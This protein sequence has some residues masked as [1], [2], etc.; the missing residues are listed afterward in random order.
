MKS[1]IS[2]SIGDKNP[3][4]ASKKINS[5]NHKG[6]LDYIN[7]AQ[8][9]LPSKQI[10]RARPIADGSIIEFARIS[11]R[12]TI[13]VT[14][15]GVWVRSFNRDRSLPTQS[16]PNNKGS[17]E[18]TK[19]ILDTAIVLGKRAASVEQKL[20]ALSVINWIWSLVSQYHVTHP[21]PQLMRE[22][23]QQFRK[24]GRDRLAEWAAEKALEETGHDRL[25]LRDIQSLGYQAQALVDTYMP[26]SA[27]ILI[28]YFVGSVK[29]S[30]PIKV[31]GYAYTLE[32]IALAVKEKHIQA[33]EAIM[34]PKVNA[35]RCIRVHSS[36]G[37]DVEH[38]DEALEMICKLS[39]AERT[40]IAIAC[41]ETARLYFSTSEQDFPLATKLREQLQPFKL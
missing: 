4:E 17:I 25:A 31:V 9:S 28:D 23:A 5:G 10:L 24:Q 3:F 6:N 27:R 38:V 20:P 7:L 18:T 22:A 36:I 40:Q 16:F 8:T 35:T 13:V 21:T 1:L 29:T 14:E 39:S 33:I 30:D 2:K 41:Y 11:D 19:K 15:D 26:N 34:P 32:R 37:S 12:Q